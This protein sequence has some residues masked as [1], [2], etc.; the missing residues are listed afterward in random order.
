MT[1]LLADLLTAL[2]RSYPARLAES[3][4]TGIGLTCGDPS[5]SVSSVL[6]AVDADRTTID[7]AVAGGFQLL[8]THHPLLFRPV[9]SVAA[10]KVKGALVHQLI[11]SGTAH[12]AVHTNADRARHG[13]NDALADTL[14]LTG[15]RPLVPAVAE[16]LDTLVTF[17]PVAEAQRVV[18]ALAAA[19]A[20]RIGEYSQASFTVQGT[21]Q[22]RPGPGAHPAVGSVGVLEQLPESRIEMVVPRRLRDRVLDALR[23][24]HPYEEPAYS[25]FEAVQLFSQDTGLGRIGELPAPLSLREFVALVAARLPATA[26]G[27]RAGGDPDRM[28]GTIAVCGGAGDGELGSATAAGADA[29]VTSDLRH[30]VAAEH[31]AEPA[32][33][34]LV[35]VA[36]W[37]GEWPWLRRAATV[38]ATALPGSV[39][40]TISQRCTDPW[41]L[42]AASPTDQR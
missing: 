41:T 7:E 24:A 15:V 42:H 32:A 31:L 36:H 3:W 11:R 12:V 2:E 1:V 9:Q 4:D 18:G 25:V 26:A 35:E 29:Y 34:A 23:A 20:G 5:A 14:G 22:F 16:Q 21:G 27:V 37:A 38:V 39:A 33:P 19:G 6:L 30:H 40:T 8:L 17:V 13:V 28:V 10:D